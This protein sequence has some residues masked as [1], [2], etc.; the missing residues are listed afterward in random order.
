MGLGAGGGGGF[1]LILLD[2]RS[3]GLASVTGAGSVSDDP[4]G[5]PKE[6]LNVICAKLHALLKR[7][8]DA[9]DKPALGLFWI[10]EQLQLLLL[11]QAIE[12]DFIVGWVK[13]DT[14]SAFLLCL[15]HFRVD[16]GRFAGFVLSR[17]GQRL[18]SSA[19]A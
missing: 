17:L 7:G 12:C 9:I 16:D 19:H 13:C 8:D 1:L 5:D 15:F 11:S 18:V 10:H 2:V 4:D 3:I 14:Q 6:K